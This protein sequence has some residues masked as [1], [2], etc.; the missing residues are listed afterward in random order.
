MVRDLQKVGLEAYE[1]DMATFRLPDDIKADVVFIK[2]AGFMT[3]EQLDEVV[4]D[5]GLV[6]VNNWHGAADY[7]SESCP[8]YSLI[9]AGVSGASGFNVY[10]VAPLDDTNTLYGFQRTA[11]TN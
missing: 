6:V 4:A 1:G 7:M 8:D 3:Q 10:G 11:P 9:D 5:E 2:N